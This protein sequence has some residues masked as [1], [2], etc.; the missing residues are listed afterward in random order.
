[1][2]NLFRSLLAGVLLIGSAMTAQAHSVT[3]PNSPIHIT[4]EGK[5][6]YKAYDNGDRVPDFSFCGYR[7]SEAAI[8]FVA[9]RVVVPAAEGDMTGRIQA[10]IDHVSSL[11]VDANGFRGAVLLEKGTYTIDGSLTIRASGVVLRGTGPGGD[12]T[13]LIGAGVTRETLIRVAGDNNRRVG[14][15]VKTAAEYIPVNASV[16]PMPANHGFRKGDRVMVTRPSTAP[17]LKA[18]GTDKL[19]NEMEYNWAVWRPGTHNIVWDRTVVA[20]DENSITLDVPLTN[21][22]DPQYGGGTVAKYTF[23]GR[24]NNVG[25]ENLR[26]VSQWDTKNEKDENHR[27]MAVT[28]ESVEDAWVRRVF[29]VYFVSSTVAVWENARRVTVEDCKSLEPV[30]EI[31]NLRRYAF[32][33]RGQQT[34][35]QRCYSE[36]GYHDFSVWTTTPGPNAFVQCLAYLPYSFSGAIGGW[37]NGILFDKTTIDGGVLSYGWLDMDGGG[38]GWTAANSLMWQCRVAQT[39]LVA[40]PTAMNWAYG[41]WTEPFG[42][43]HYELSH[44]FITQ[45]ESIF[46]DQLISRTGRS[47]EELKKI[48]AYTTDETVAPM[49][50]YAAWM[51]ELSKT[52]QPTMYEWIDEMIA[53]YPLPSETGNPTVLTSSAKPA[54]PVTKAP[55]MTIDRGWISRG[56]KV[57]IGGTGRG[58]GSLTLYSPGREA[59]Y[60]TGETIDLDTLGVQMSKSGPYVLWHGPDLWYERRRGDHERNRQADANVIGPFSEMPFSR[61]GIGEA[62]DR[63]SK[64]DLDQYNPW[65]YERVKKFGEVSDQYGFAF[66]NEH[67]LQ[68]NIIEEGAHWVDYPWRS[69]NNINDLGF[70]EP[71]RMSGDKRIFMGVEFYDV[72]HPVRRAYH[73]KYIRQSVN[74]VGTSRSTIQ[75]LSFEFTGPKHFVDFWVDVNKAC[76][77]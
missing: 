62:W 77:K 51:S 24:I 46:Y 57:M 52:P 10:A 44:T 34:L 4:P 55:E 8:P 40:P 73:E 50:E 60:G 76:E 27:W 2:K 11:P 31:A 21:A 61:S 32:Q 22:L 42:N 65:Y 33:T 59:T 41:M 5:V 23:T 54:K 72:D 66:F 19:G 6:V 1:M 67:Y 75:S 53:A 69:A 30:S 9:A 49:P 16:I 74:N 39:K 58:T 43:G 26:L 17:W 3:T 35:F 37:A 48:Y 64:Y 71:P 20:A 15:A 28:L 47:T 12:E 38:A 25:V 45:V 70:P 14:E 13:V 7:A 29:S 18:L 36:Y 68:H 56:N 63:L